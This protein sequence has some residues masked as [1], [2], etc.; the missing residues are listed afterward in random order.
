M[1]KL[2]WERQGSQEKLSKEQIEAAMAAYTSKAVEYFE[3]LSN[4]CANTNYKVILSDG[5]S[6]ILRIYTRDREALHRERA[7]HELVKGQIPVPAFLFTNEAKEIFPYPYAILEYVEG[8]LFRDLILQDNKEGVESCGYNA[9]VYLAKMSSFQ[10]ETS[11]F[12][13]ADLKVKPFQRDQKYLPFIKEALSTSSLDSR[14]IVRLLTELERYATLINE[15]GEQKSLT[16][17]DY[18]PSNML[19]KNTN[20]EWKIAAILDWEFAFSSTPFMDMGL[21]LRFAHKLPA[22]YQLAFLRGIEDAHHDLLDS[23]WELKAKLMDVLSLVSLCASSDRTTRPR[24]FADVEGLLW[25]T[26]KFLSSFSSQH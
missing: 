21:M 6:L 8:I 16:H 5:S 18:D 10:F 19:V 2:N 13:E 23:Q 26:C 24:M 22:Y 12:F 17:A 11:G 7:I 15:L 25:H 20:G 1:L 4:G 3:L 14:L 9:G